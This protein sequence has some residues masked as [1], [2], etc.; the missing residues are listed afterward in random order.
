MAAGGLCPGTAI[1]RGSLDIRQQVCAKS[2]LRKRPE[3]FCLALATRKS[4]SARLLENGVLQ[5]EGGR[6]QQNRSRTV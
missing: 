2:M 3:T 6:T 5:T 4:L 1:V